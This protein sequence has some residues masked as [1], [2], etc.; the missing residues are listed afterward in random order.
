MKKIAITKN[1]FA[2]V[3][4]QDFKWL[5]TYSWHNDHGYARR[6]F[7]VKGKM[8][9]EYM[10]NMIACTSSGKRV[11]HINLNPLDNRRINLRPVTIQQNSV[12]RGKTKSNT[13]G[14]KGV[15]RIKQVVNGK[16]YEYWL[17]K[18][19]LIVDGKKKGIHIGQSKDPKLA[20]EMYRE[21]VKHNFGE[22][23]VH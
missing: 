23:Y 11:D 16:K 13:S 1:T 21:Y 22:S 19:Q 18:I 12:N 20:S 5:N 4:N 17:A 9:F 6:G 10:H 2:I 14:Y 15:Y 8:K 7:R 3:D